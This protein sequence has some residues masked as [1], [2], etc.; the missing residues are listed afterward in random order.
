MRSRV[1]CL[2]LLLSVSGSFPDAASAGRGRSRALGSVVQANNSH[3]DN[4]DALAGGDLYACDVLDTDSYGSLRA[5][6]N[7]S[8]ILLGPSSEVVLD[9]QP[10]AVRVIITNGTTTFSAPSASVLEIDT[11]AGVLRQSGQYY[12]GTVNVIGPKELIVSASRSDLSFNSGGQLHTVPAGKS[13]RVTFDQAADPSCHKA[14]DI[15]SAHPTNLRLVILGAG[16]VAG[17]GGYQIWQEL[18][19][20][21]TKP[22]EW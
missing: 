1:L 22:D 13:A 17:F 8:Q 15:L 20:S 7:G 21:E 4:Q 19:E 5:Q 18:N 10:N 16:I 12:S 14:G 9:G 11:P 2:V 6:F 3:V